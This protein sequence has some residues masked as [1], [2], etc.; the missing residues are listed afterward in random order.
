MARKGRDEARDSDMA[1]QRRRI[2]SS[3]LFKLGRQKTYTTVSVARGWTAIVDARFLVGF[4]L[5]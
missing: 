1:C 4:V 3:T 2:G 5:S